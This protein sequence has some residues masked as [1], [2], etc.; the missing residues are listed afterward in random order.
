MKI[1]FAC[2]VLTLSLSACSGGKP[3]IGNSGPSTNPVLA[4][5]GGVVPNG[6]TGGNGY[7]HAQLAQAFVNAYNNEVGQCDAY[8]DNCANP[9]PGAGLNL[10]K[11]VTQQG[12]YIV[13]QNG[14]GTFDA[15][16]A[17]GYNPSNWASVDPV[18]YVTSNN[19]FSNLNSIGNGN[20]QDPI[21]HIIFEAAQP[22]S[23]DLEKIAAIKEGLQL[24]Q[25]TL[26]LQSYGFSED[27]SLQVARLVSQ[28][29]KAPHGSMTEN[30]YDGFSR[31]L[32]GS[33]VTKLKN[34]ITAEVKGDHKALNDIIT[35]AASTNG[36]GADQMKQVLS[37]VAGKYGAALH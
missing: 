15:V 29:Q 13:V 20:F 3:S 22:T 21:T 4:G 33:S 37:Y 2:I 35:T 7:T 11:T 26:Q 1:T 25:A 14:Y 27:R 8:S 18:S 23:K 5:S 10:V 32:T 19:T 34:A 9:F 16:Y 31:Q 12:G 36:V 17:D 24:R 28:L 30:D 6:G